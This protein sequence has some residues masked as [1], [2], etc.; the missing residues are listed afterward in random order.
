MKGLFFWF[1]F[2]FILNVMFFGG[3]GILCGMMISFKLLFKDK[4]V[5]MG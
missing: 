5:I 1:F 3:K 2:S 4:L